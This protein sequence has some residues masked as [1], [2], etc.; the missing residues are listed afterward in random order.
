M[1]KTMETTTVYWGYIWIMETR[2][3]ATIMGLGFKAEGSGLFA[4]CMATRHRKVDTG[5]R[6]KC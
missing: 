4:A 1:E 3:E 2:M 6:M 5:L